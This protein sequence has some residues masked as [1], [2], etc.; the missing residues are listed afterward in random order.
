MYFVP[1]Y[2]VTLAKKGV[3]DGRKLPNSIEAHTIVPAKQG[4]LEGRTLP[5]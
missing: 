1:L 3:L 2:K 5:N 4:V